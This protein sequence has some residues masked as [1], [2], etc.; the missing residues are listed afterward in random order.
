MHLSL[1][2]DNAQ[3]RRIADATEHISR[4]QAQLVHKAALIEE[5]LCRIGA[6]LAGIDMT[7]K[8]ILVA[9]TPPKASELNLM[10]EEV[11]LP[12]QSTPQTP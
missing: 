7:L 11:P 10:V 12:S 4:S 2:I 6:T 3:L 5:D 9:M 1:F 8:Q